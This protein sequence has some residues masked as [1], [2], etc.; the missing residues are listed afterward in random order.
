MDRVE[1]MTNYQEAQ[2]SY[3]SVL[4]KIPNLMEEV[5]LLH[6]SRVA[7][8]NAFSE[9]TNQVI[10]HQAAVDS[11]QGAETRDFEKPLVDEEVFEK[12]AQK[13]A[14]WADVEIQSRSY[15]ELSGQ[16]VAKTLL[17]ENLTAVEKL[18]LIDS[19]HSR[20]AEH[21]E[22][23]FTSSY[24]ALTQLD[25]SLLPYSKVVVLSRDGPD[26]FYQLESQGGIRVDEL[27]N[28]GKFVISAGPA[29]GVMVRK[30]NSRDYWLAQIY[31][32]KH[33][34][35][36]EFDP[37]ELSAD[38]GFASLLSDESPNRIK[39]GDFTV[40]E[41][42]E[43]ANNEAHKLTRAIAAEHIGANRTKAVIFD[44]RSIDKLWQSLLDAVYIRITNQVPEP[45]FVQAPRI[46]HYIQVSAQFEVENLSSERADILG[47]IAA[48]MGINKDSLKFI[49]ED[50]LEELHNK[51]V[52]GQLPQQTDDIYQTGKLLLDAF[53]GQMFNHKL[54]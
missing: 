51:I 44:Q 28:S 32:E 43:R 41:L 52:N 37:I 18:A 8:H 22:V 3:G 46:A 47:D 5:E 53:L 16:V 34:P 17:A 40:M 27:G 36:I 26:Y 23:R 38:A 30:I 21:P 2:V 25:E 1:Q 24:E 11:V 15:S 31:E 42:L 29:R 48:V 19:Y 54:P 12:R 45:L 4:E 13:N 33:A 35:L 10:E 50:K 6:A 20:A 49:M 7:Y 39:V 14:A 9:Y